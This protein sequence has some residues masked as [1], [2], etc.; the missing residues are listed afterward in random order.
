MNKCLKEFKKNTKKQLNGTKK[1]MQD[2]KEKLNKDKQILKKHQIEIS[3][4]E[5]LLN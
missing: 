4:M 3:E 2:M 1:T 5:C